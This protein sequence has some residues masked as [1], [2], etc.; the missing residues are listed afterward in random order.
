MGVGRRPGAALARRM[1]VATGFGVGECRMLALLGVADRLGVGTRD[2]V[3]VG[4]GANVGVTLGEGVGV[5]V[6][7]GVG[8]AARE[9]KVVGLTL[10]SA[11]FTA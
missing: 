2:G 1:G 3:G 8:V 7:V 9:A 10:A 5:G 6:K 4:V 11:S